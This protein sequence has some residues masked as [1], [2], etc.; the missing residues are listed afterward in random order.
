MG[1]GEMGVR[2][3]GGGTCQ[4]LMLLLVSVGVLYIGG[5]LD[6]SVAT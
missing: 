1:V 4:V 5:A 3:V 2:G 6:V